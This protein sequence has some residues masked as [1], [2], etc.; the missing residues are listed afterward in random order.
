MGKLRPGGWMLP[1]QLFNPA[2]QTFDLIV[3]D[4]LAFDL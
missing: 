3:F 1:I 2:H 4:Y